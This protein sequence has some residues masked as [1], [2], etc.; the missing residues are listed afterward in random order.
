MTWETAEPPQPP[1]V[2]DG[3]EGAAWWQRWDAGETDRLF[4]ALG[5]FADLQDP[6]FFRQV[7]VWVNKRMGTGGWSAFVVP[8][9]PDFRSR[10]AALVQAMEQHRDADAVLRALAQSLRQLCGDDAAATVAFDRLVDELAP[11]GRLPAQRLRD[12]TATLEKL[13]PALPLVAAGDALTRA[14]LPGEPRA[15]RGAETV[16]SMVRRLDDAREAAPDPDGGSPADAHGPLVLRF[17]AELARTLPEE[18]ASLLSA[19]IALAAEELQ[20]PAEARAALAARRGP[21]A[22][23]P[24]GH[25]VLQIRLR[26][27]AVGKQEY[28]VEAALFDWSADG[29]E[30]PRKRTGNHSY[31]IREL[32]Q[33]GRTCLV[34]WSDLAARLDEADEVRVEFLLPLSL[35]GHPVERWA[36]DAGG[37]LLGH[38]YPVVIRSLDRIEQRSWRRHWERRW[39]ALHSPAAGGTGW[40]GRLGWMATDDDTTPEGGCDVVHVRGRDGQIR[41]WLDAHPDAPGLALAF[42]YDHHDPRHTVPVHEAVCEGVPFM[43][44]RRD[45]GDPAE[46]AGRLRESEHEHIT[47]LP[48]RVRLWRRGADREDDADMHN[49]LTLLW[50]DPTCVQKTSALRPPGERPDPL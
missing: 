43:V 17:L 15:L 3:A 31:G 13:Q 6:Q 47:G 27:T 29:L 25:R 23:A 21:L 46:L 45:D 34:E 35:L 42:A 39:H 9:R 36:T 32:W 8:D 14:A 30:N 28:D 11:A 44:W 38:K 1:V 20:L 41:S 2:A 26:E 22:A 5:A 40:A 16:P 19:H 24:A 49:H 4:T 18:P 7:L 50:D 10:I 37:Y 48:S 33:L 12:I